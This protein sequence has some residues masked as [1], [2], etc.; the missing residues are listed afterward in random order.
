MAVA[1]RICRSF[2]EG[3][4]KGPLAESSRLAV[5]GLSGVL[6]E[7]LS[8]TQLLRKGFFCQPLGHRAGSM[9]CPASDPSPQVARA[10]VAPA[11]VNPVEMAAAFKKRLAPTPPR[12][13]EPEKPDQRRKPCNSTRLP[14]PQ[15]R[16]AVAGIVARRQGTGE[17]AK[18]TAQPAL[19]HAVRKLIQCEVHDKLESFHRLA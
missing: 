9:F 2:I 17:A 5:V 11:S 12:P 18:A 10:G 6:S 14:V 3:L 15:P 7:T 8:E 16:A 4:Q 19:C 1:F 13:R